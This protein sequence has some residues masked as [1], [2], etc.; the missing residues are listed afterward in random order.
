MVEDIN[1]ILDNFEIGFS[2]HGAME[3]MTPDKFLVLTI[4]NGKLEPNRYVKDEDFNTLEKALVNNKYT[5]VREDIYKIVLSN[6]IFIF[7]MYIDSIVKVCT[8]YYI[9]KNNT[10][11]LVAITGQLEQQKE[12]MSI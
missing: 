9:E 4:Y 5:K 10:N 12:S 6:S 8:G 1:T 11:R 2:E 7:K 3:F